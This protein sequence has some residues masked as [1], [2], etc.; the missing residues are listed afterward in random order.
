MQCKRPTPVRL[1]KRRRPAGAHIEPQQADEQPGEGLRWPLT[2]ENLNRAHEA[3]GLAVITQGRRQAV[4][5]SIRRRSGLARW[6]CR[7]CWTVP[8]RRPP[9]SLQQPSYLHPCVLQP[10]SLSGPW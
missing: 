10:W 1:A 5:L 6:P 9:E 8:M 2:Q 7:Q 3:E 4:L